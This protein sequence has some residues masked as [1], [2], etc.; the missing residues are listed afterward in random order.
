MMLT[1]QVLTQESLASQML[2]L[3]SD[4]TS[5]FSTV[6]FCGFKGGETGFTLFLH[7]H[8]GLPCHGHDSH[9][10]PGPGVSPTFHQTTV[11][12]AATIMVLPILVGFYNSNGTCKQFG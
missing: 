10:S 4:H 12:P 2:T 1:R 3:L 6:L 7:F 8:L 5:Y 9:D 11:S